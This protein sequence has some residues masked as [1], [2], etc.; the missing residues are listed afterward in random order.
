MA[1]KPTHNPDESRKPRLFSVG[2]RACDALLLVLFFGGP[3]LVYYSVIHENIPIN[4]VHYLMLLITF[5]SLLGLLRVRIAFAL[6]AVPFFAWA[7][8]SVVRAFLLPPEW[9]DLVNPIYVCKWAVSIVFEYLIGEY[10]WKK[11]SGIDFLEWIGGV[12]ERIK[13]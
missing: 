5:I 12:F 2:Y 13:G 10:F 4:W 9:S 7:G 11:Y 1:N 8:Y 6:L 3:T